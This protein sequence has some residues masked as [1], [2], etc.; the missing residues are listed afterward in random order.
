[1][2]WD[3]LARRI[4]EN[5][6]NRLAQL[7]TTLNDA[8]ASFKSKARAAR[9]MSYALLNVYLD[10]T[11]LDSSED[12]VDA[13]IERCS[14]P[15]VF[16]PR[17]DLTPEERLLKSAIERVL[18]SLCRHA[19]VI[20]FGSLKREPDPEALSQWGRNTTELMKWLDWA[21]WVACDEECGPDGMCLIPLWPRM[22][23]DPYPDKRPTKAH[24]LPRCYYFDDW[25]EDPESQKW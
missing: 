10:M 19:A 17:S 20:L 7:N 12:W 5:W 4:V 8:R 13:T 21:T 3:G 9:Y 1:M 16:T 18:L 2:E 23:R 11:S 24:G 14:K 25:M 22:Y 6:A 15:D